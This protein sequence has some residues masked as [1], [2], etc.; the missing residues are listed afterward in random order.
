MVNLWR[1]RSTPVVEESIVLHR[2]LAGKLQANKSTRSGWLR[3]L[4]MLVRLLFASLLVFAFWISWPSPASAP[5][6]EV[7][8]GDMGYPLPSAEAVA[9]ADGVTQIKAAVETEPVAGTEASL[10][11]AQHTQ[12]PEVTTDSSPS[13][14]STEAAE[15]LPDPPQ[16]TD[17]AELP[18]R[19]PLVLG[20][21]KIAA[22]LVTAS[23][24]DA[25]AA[26]EEVRSLLAQIDANTRDDAG[27]ESP[28]A[29][30]N[31]AT[32][33]VP[34]EV[35]VQ[36]GR[37][38]GPVATPSPTPT[39]NGDGAPSIIHPYALAL[40]PLWETFTPRPPVEADHYWLGVAFP[41]AYNQFYSVSYQFGSTAGGRYRPH[42]GVDI[43]NP[44][45][46]PVLAM[47]AGEVIHAGPDS[48][49]LLGPYNNFYGNTVVIKLEERLSL[50]QGEKDVYLLY[51]HL[52]E[53]HT[54][55]G[56]QVAAGDPVGTVGMTGIA[57]GPHL[58]VEVRVGQ[59]SYMTAVNPALWI[60]PLPGT[61]TVAVRLLNAEGRSWAGA[62]V[63]LLRYED[64]GTRWVG[65]IE[66]YRSEERLLGDPVWGEN[67]AMSNLPSGNY[68]VSAEIN[69]EKVGQNLV[70]NPG[71]TTFVTLRT[72]Q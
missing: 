15:S 51:G 70:V 66:T 11:E 65:T 68:Y 46:T 6:G 52:N 9:E 53:V 30:D 67:G 36:P 63:S 1:R 47:A 69:G 16:I 44:T 13:T 55:R 42:H 10:E 19:P 4:L 33:L 12:S 62:K 45:G 56:V 39:G 58:H 72:Q 29:E 26:R 8:L 7:H 43:S 18:E 57:L 2:T 23:G 61:G 27:E 59:N 54:V 20:F 64:G 25:S 71:E 40:G 34:V 38:S 5:I 49:T 24:E 32:S 31:A 41:P 22:A 17:S 35:Q 60:R 14:S 28:A 50:P 37:E 48:P 3:A 21:T